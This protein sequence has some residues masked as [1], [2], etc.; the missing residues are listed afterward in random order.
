MQ[1]PF[2]PRPPGSP[3]LPVPLKIRG[4][5]GLPLL[6][7]RFFRVCGVTLFPPCSMFFGCSERFEFSPGDGFAVAH[8]KHT[9]RTPSAYIRKKSYSGYNTTH[10]SVGSAF[11]DLLMKQRFGSTPR[12]FVDFCRAL[13]SCFL[14]SVR[15]FNSFSN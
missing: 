8:W 11:P 12:T 4:P 1:F 3:R 14:E 9:L 10:G 2:P 6:A 5:S 7:S 13:F 15:R